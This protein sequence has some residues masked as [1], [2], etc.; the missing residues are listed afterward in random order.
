MRI[1]LTTEGG[2]AYFPGLSKPVVV[3]SGRLSQEQKAELQRLTE[4]ARFFELP[5]KADT[6]RRGADYRRYTL[7]IEGD[8]RHHTVQ[9]TDLIDNPALKRLVHYVES[10]GAKAPR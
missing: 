7:T 1:E 6:P 4:E 3:D 10:L 2:V 9:F 5:E 8:A